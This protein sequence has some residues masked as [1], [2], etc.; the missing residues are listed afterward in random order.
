MTHLSGVR[1]KPV[2]QRVPQTGA[3]L[4]L[5]SCKS[6][7]AFRTE[8]QRDF[9]DFLKKNSLLTSFTRFRAI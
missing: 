1:I 6:G 2:Q 5:P 9:C 4:P 8:P 7:R 3:E